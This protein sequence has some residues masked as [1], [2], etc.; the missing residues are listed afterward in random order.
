MVLQVNKNKT[1]FITSEV[2]RWPGSLTGAWYFVYVDKKLNDEI[3]TLGRRYGS[4]FVSVK[5]TVGKTSWD[6]AL[7][8][9][10]KEN[11]YLISI[12]SSVRKKENISIGDILKIKFELT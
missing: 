9:Y 10:K 6:T 11:V 12:K 1:F 4:G 3:K 7:F 2:W 5:V 8:P